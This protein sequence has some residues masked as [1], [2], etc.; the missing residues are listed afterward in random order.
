M[1]DNKETKQAPVVETASVEHG[2]MGWKLAMRVMQSDLFEQLDD[3][4]C[5]ECDA[6]VRANPYMNF[7]SNADSAPAPAVDAA[8]Q[9]ER[10]D[11]EAAMEK[12]GRMRPFTRWPSDDSYTDDRI[13]WARRGWLAALSRASEAEAA[14]RDALPNAIWTRHGSGVAEWWS[15]KGYECHKDGAG[16]WIVRKGGKELY[17]HTYLQVVMAH[18][19]RAILAAAPLPPSEQQPVPQL[20]ADT[21]DAVRGT[22]G[23]TVFAEMSNSDDLW[24]VWLDGWLRASE[25]HAASGLSDDVRSR[26]EFY[27]A[28]YCKSTSATDREAGKAMYAL[29]AAKGDC[30]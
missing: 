29:L 9:D 27:A 14:A 21:G 18:A 17:R 2:Q 5:A 8:A 25:Q 13:E 19:E 7:R 22:F 4:E 23:K 24:S 26:L 16:W 3:A 10:E 1:S 12:H 15:F 28:C 6:L 30:Q 11:F 20:F